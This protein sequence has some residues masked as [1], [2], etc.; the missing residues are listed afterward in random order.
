M[1]KEKIEKIEEEYSKEKQFRSSEVREEYIDAD[2]RTV[3]LAL[4]S[5]AP[6]SRSFGLE[7]LDHSSDSID[8]SF[9]SSGRAPLLLNHDQREQIG[10]V[11]KFY[12]DSDQKRTI[13]E[14]RFGRSALA[15]ETFQDVREGI[16]GNV[17]VGYQIQ[18]MK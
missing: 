12:L 11:E 3:K 1:E 6:V 5:E 14:V 9:M 16:K 17:S 18:D 10:V 4:T 8:S 2:A 15:E 7:I 13:A